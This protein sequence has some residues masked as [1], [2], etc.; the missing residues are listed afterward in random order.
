MTRIDERGCH[1]SG[2]SLAALALYERALAAAC[3]WRT[4]ADVLAAAAQREAPRFAMAYA[5]QA[6]LLVCSRDPRRVHSARTVLAR[7]A[8]LP[9]N[10]RERMHLAAIA[11]VLADR[12]D[13]AKAHLS[14][15]LARHPRDLLALQAVH[16]LDYA[17]GDIDGMIERVAGVLPAW[18]NGVPGYPS[19]LAMHAFALEEIGELEFAE[20]RAREALASNPGNARAHHVMAHV[21]EASERADAG[22]SWLN[23]HAAA[24][25]PDT[26]VATHGW[27]H[28]ALFH[29]E[30]READAALALYDARVRRERS[31]DVSDLI[32]ASSLLWRVRLQGIDVEARWTELADA[33]D[34]HIDDGFCSF[35]DVHA[36]LAF[37]G[38]RDD[39]RARR[40]E[41]A[42]AHSRRS[43]RH[44]ETTRRLG[45]PACRALMAH[46]RGDD[47]LAIALLAS[48]PTRAHRLGGSHAQR[49]VL[50]LTLRHAIDR[51]R[52]PARRPSAARSAILEARPS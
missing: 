13:L 50:H 22:L 36:M 11:A 2:A 1:V 31:T 47:G 14:D 39:A 42:L 45:L 30:R 43:T 34:G 46:G 3:N 9:G 29:L 25:Q 41:L 38:A 10:E 19:V 52:R 37:V 44:G 27:W 8:A 21:F 33:W 32:D 17:T 23:A 7:A 6:Y 18:S 26:T 5:L 12:Y 20:E 51:M 24:W 28:L 15:L 4:G 35:S 49:D 40:L 48:L 16:A